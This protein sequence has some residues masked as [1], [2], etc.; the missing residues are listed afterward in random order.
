MSLVSNIAR[1]YRAPGSVIAGIDAQG[2]REPQVLFFLLLSCGLI[3]MSQLPVLSRAAALDPDATFEQLMAGVLFGVMFML[4]LVLY[5][6]AALLQL[7]MRAVSGPV[8]GIRVR[9]ALFWA[10]LC[11]TPLM[12]VHGTLRGILGDELS[13]QLFGFVVFGA[14]LYI[15][16]AGLRTVVRITRSSQ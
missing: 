3:F 15:L 12:I 7:G 13:V 16:G 9:L 1:S 10:I 14:F 5:G 4:P 2:L 6:I 11:A 8:Q